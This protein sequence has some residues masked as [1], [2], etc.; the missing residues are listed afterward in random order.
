LK[1]LEPVRA[2]KTISANLEARVTL[3][4][5]GDLG[6]LLRQYAAQ[7]PA[8][9]IVS[10]VEVADGEIEGALPSAAL[11]ALRI[12]VERA[13]G[14]KCERCWNYSVHVG[15]SAAHPTFCERCLAAVEEIARGKNKQG[16]GAAASRS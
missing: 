1:A 8:L 13:C 9:F 3:A 14:K 2:A 15:D 7:L 4:A 10:Q 11:P 5:S 6:A 16:G 12:K